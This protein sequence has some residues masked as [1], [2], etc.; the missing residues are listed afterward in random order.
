MVRLSRIGLFAIAGA[1]A[2]AAFRDTF[3]SHSETAA[4]VGSRE[5]KS[6]TV[7]EII[8][9]LG[10]PN[11]SPEAAS[12]VTGIWVDYQ[13]FAAHV[14]GGKAESDSVFLD[15]LIWPQMVQFKISAWHDTLVARRGQVT[16]AG[17]DSVY[18]G[19][20]IRM[21]QHIL[22]RPS[23]A[24]S[25]DTVKAKAEAAR[26]AQM[27]KTGDFARLAKQY[28]ADPSNKEDAGYLPPS[29]RGTFVPEFE[30]AGWQLQPG[31]VTGVVQT[32]FGWHVIRRTPLAEGRS[33]FEAVVRQRQTTMADSIYI[34]RLMEEA[35][36]EIRSNAPETIRKAAKDAAGA[37]R[38]SKVVATYQG[39]SFT[40]Q[41]VNRWLATYAQQQL[42][43]IQEAQ[44][45]VLNNLI[46]YLVQNQLLLKKADSAGITVSPNMRENLIN[47][48]RSQVNDLKSVSGLDVPE[49]SDS[50]K[51]TQAERKKLAGE[52]IDDYF[53]RLT[54]NQAQFRPVP[55][56]LSAELRV[57][58]DYRVYDSGIAKAVELVQAAAKS[59]SA[60]R[61]LP[62][63]PGLQPAP[64][65]PPTPGSPP[66]APPV[67]PPAGGQRP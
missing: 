4:R 54:N 41:D 2:C 7:A 27:A 19:D 53:Q 28:S 9:R 46:K 18:A 30:A 56:T 52:K 38:S 61:A 65:G 43:Q 3:T 29:P 50:S 42:A 67:P 10:G 25:A 66:P 14:A 39:G 60:S 20:D 57:S 17:I 13:L 5:L 59:D 35:R 22:V 11:A 63:P 40:L 12:A 49:L 21:F 44:D 24:T 37:A 45:T 55:P 6:A 1:T 8:T 62:Q 48:I 51:V 23:G 31:D 16:A 33:R 34:A 58:G 15:R 64:G 36:I 26:V 47:Q 32:P